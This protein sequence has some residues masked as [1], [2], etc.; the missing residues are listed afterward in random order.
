M[1]DPGFEHRQ[2][3]QVFIFQ[4]V[5]IWAPPSL[6]LNRFRGPLSQGLKRLGVKLATQLH[7]VLRLRTNGAIPP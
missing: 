6:L 2:G 5:E 1:D 3:Q 4:N 7:L